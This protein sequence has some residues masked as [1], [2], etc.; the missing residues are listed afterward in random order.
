MHSPCTSLQDDPTYITDPL[1]TGGCLGEALLF[2]EL[3]GDLA[4][5]RLETAQVF[6]GLSKW[7]VHW[8]V[9]LSPTVCLAYTTPTFLKD[10]DCRMVWAIPEPYAK[11][12]VGSSA[13][14]FDPDFT[15]AIKRR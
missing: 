13:S 4:S 10:L 1:R 11:S 3:L 9:H 15:P 5:K 7:S 14:D 8:S 2:F 12:L 6:H